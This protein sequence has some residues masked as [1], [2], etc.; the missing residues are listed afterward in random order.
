MYVVH[1]QGII[2]RD[3]KPANLLWTEDHA[4]VKIS[5]FGVSHVSEAL[6]RASPLDH[7]VGCTGDDDKLLRKTAG[8]PAFF[9]PELCNPAES[10]PTPSTAD[11]AS[12]YFPSNA[13][14]SLEPSGVVAAASPPLSPNGLPLSSTFISRPSPTSNSAQP[15]SRAVIGKGIDIWALGVTL[16]CLLFGD[17]P[18]MADTEYELYNVIVRDAIRVPERMG[19]EQAWTGVPTHNNWE[20][21][22][23]GEEGREVVDLLGRLLEKDPA[24]RITLDQVKVSGIC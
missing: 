22:G 11:S 18:F 16:Y 23:D 8:S 4:V 10:T 7:T 19:K 15:R 14:A 17:T 21:K 9:A 5:D 3:I 6:L 20:G 2:H 24:Q 13:R 1:Y 12:N